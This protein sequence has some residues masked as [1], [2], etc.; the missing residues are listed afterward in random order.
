MSCQ[1]PSAEEEMA[2][3]LPDPNRP[4]VSGWYVQPGKRIRAPWPD[5]TEQDRKYWCRPSSEFLTRLRASN[6]YRQML[7]TS[8]ECDWCA[9]LNT[10]SHMVCWKCGDGQ[11]NHAFLK[12]GREDWHFEVSPEIRMQQGMTGGPE[13]RP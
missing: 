4:W 3:A 7:Q 5:D 12:I 8:W 1:G 10:M 2:R 13:P 6:R 11:S 9:Q